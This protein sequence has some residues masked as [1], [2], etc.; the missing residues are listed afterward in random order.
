[1]STALLRCARGALANVVEHAA[2]TEATVS[3]TYH[4][5]SVSLDVRDNGIGF[6]PTAFTPGPTRGRGLSG[7]DHRARHFGGR[8]AVESAP[9]EGTVLAVL[10][11]ITAPR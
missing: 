5:E 7:I 6:D 8:S 3:L 10:I 4:P 2:A 1:M 11:P 9:G